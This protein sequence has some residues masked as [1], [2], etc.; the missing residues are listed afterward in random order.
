MNIIPYDFSGKTVRFIIDENGNPWWVAKDV[1]IVLG[2]SD[3]GKAIRSLDEDESK[4][5]RVTDNLGRKQ[6]TYIINESGLY[7]LLSRSNKKKAKEFQRWI[8]HDVL[9]QIRKTGAYQVQNLSRLEILKMAIDSEE[10][11]IKLEIENK[12][13]KPKAQIYDF[14]SSSTGLVCISDCAKILNIRPHAFS[15]RLKSDGYCFIRRNQ[16][17]A[18]D[19]YIDRGWFEMKLVPARDGSKTTYRQ[20]FITPLGTNKFREIYNPGQKQLRIFA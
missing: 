11:R 12:V 13:L 17:V 16:I 20:T 6:D 7:R 4:I 18:Y 15:A 10:A 14:V 1:C 3:T 19:Q 2:L 5:F 9:P 8:F